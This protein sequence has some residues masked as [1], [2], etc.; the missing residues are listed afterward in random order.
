MRDVQEITLFDAVT[1][2]AVTSSTNA[3]PTVI[4]ATAHG[5]VTGDRVLIFGHSTNTDANGIWNVVKV[6]NNSFKIKDEFTGVEVNANG[7]GTG[8]IV[9]KA[10]PVLLVP[11]FRHVLFEVFTSGTATMTLK[12]L[13]S[14]GK[15]DS[16]DSSPRHDFPNMGATQSTSNMWSYHGMID[17][18]AASG[19]AGSTGIVI[20]GTD[21]AKVFSANT[22]GM[23]YF[24]LIPISWTAG[25]LTVK[26]KMFND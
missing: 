20:A 18:N 3:S 5:F 9:C 19:V 11:D 22:D 26:A 15:K 25:V 2:V 6:D 16:A 7:A 12:L 17:Q 24:A 1:P 8:G 10:P 21:I 23:K 13:A 4:T 14:L